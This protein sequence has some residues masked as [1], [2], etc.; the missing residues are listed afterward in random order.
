MY[1]ISQVILGKPSNFIL[2][3]FDKYVCPIA[4]H[5]F[6]GIQP[7]IIDL[8]P[9]VYFFLF[10]KRIW[11]IFAKQHDGPGTDA[12]TGSLPLCCKNKIVLLNR[13]LRYS[14]TWVM[15]SLQTPALL[16]ASHPGT[17][18]QLQLVWGR[19]RVPSLQNAEGMQHSLKRKSVSSHDLQGKICSLLKQE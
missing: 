12:E 16:A 14:P 17:S 15:M 5:V 4:I 19:M 1:T 8:H 9:M 13:A 3:E 10:C 2:Q 6:P 18:R 7:Y 11:K